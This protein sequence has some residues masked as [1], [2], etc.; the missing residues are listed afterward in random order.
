MKG[1]FMDL[2]KVTR[3][4]EKI[5]DVSILTM[6]T[7]DIFVLLG[8]MMLMVMDVLLRLVCNFSI[9]GAFELV[10]FGMIL[11]VYLGLATTQSS[12]MHISIDILTSKFP[13]RAQIIIGN[14]NSFLSLFIVSLI[15]WRGLV[16][17]KYV[18]ASGRDSD[19][20]HI[21]VYYFQIFLVI[22]WLLLALAL[23]VDLC[24]NLMGV[25]KT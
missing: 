5:T 19:V 7:V 10:E 1:I 8:M 14:V 2:R 23:L 22:G 24:K 21:P 3:F 6:S 18:W 4:L 12:K 16:Y 9:P 20:L 15:A 25:K 17:L 13:E 11:V